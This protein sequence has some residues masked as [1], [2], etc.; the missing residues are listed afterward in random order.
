MKS[1]K[2]IVAAMVLANTAGASELRNFAQISV[3][4]DGALSPIPSDGTRI[5][6][7]RH[8]ESEDPLVSAEVSR[9]IFS[10]KCFHR[11]EKALAYEVRTE[12]FLRAKEDFLRETGGK[13][14]D[15]IF[16]THEIRNR[17]K[18]SRLQNPTGER[19]ETRTVK[20]LELA[21][22]G[23]SASDFEVRAERIKT[24]AAT[25]CLPP[26]GFFTAFLRKATQT[27][28]A[29]RDQARKAVLDQEK[30]KNRLNAIANGG[31]V[32]APESA[33]E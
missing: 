32:P 14:V 17:F 20:R 28:L 2:W 33:G 18:V 13:S 26:P 22:A 1:I 30:A 29:A 19:I 8:L 10:D 16:D 25:E 31:Q 7:V 24:P 15:V 6:H 23:A 4:S 11:M 21:S 12:A 27:E 9:L 3:R 5:F